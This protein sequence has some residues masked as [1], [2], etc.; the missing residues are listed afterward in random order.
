MASTIVLYDELA[1]A[2]TG[3]TWAYTGTLSS[4]PAAPGTYNGSVDFAT[5]DAGDYEYTYTVTSGAIT[6]SSTITVAWGGDTPERVNDTCEDYFNLPGTNLAN[7]SFIVI[8]E[9]DNRY[10]CGVMAS[11]ESDDPDY[12]GSWNQGTYTGDLWFG[13]KLQ[14]RSTDYDIQV[15]VSSESFSDADAA[16]GLAIQFFSNTVS[17]FACENDVDIWRVTSIRTSKKLT[18]SLQAAIVVE[19][20]IRFRVVSITPGKFRIQLTSNCG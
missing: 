6:H 19:T 3:G 9:E 8:A 12:P 17:G 4:Y 11:P 15:E 7:T 20:L 16:K 13:F 1:D 10:E 2:T 14:P 5:Y 18:T